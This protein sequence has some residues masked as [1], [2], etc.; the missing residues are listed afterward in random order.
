MT[1]TIDILMVTYN[2]PESTR[3]SL[4]RLLD[5]CTDGMHVWLWHNGDHEETLAVVHEL[6]DHP[7][8][9]K[10]HHSA[11]NQRLWAPSNWLFENSEADLLSKVDDDNVVSPDWAERLSAAHRDYDRF[12]VL[13][14]WRFQDEDLV[15]ELAERKIA[16]YGGHRIM[17]NLWVEGSCFL[18]KRACRDESGLL[19]PGQSMT[20]YFRALGVD[21]G[22]IN[23]WLYPFVRYE[24]LDDPRAEHALVKTDEEFRRRMPLT[25]QYN[26]VQSVAEWTDQLRRSARAVQAASP[27]PR[28]WKGWRQQRRRLKRVMRRL[29]GQR[30]HW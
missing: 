10:F 6:A 8:V 3:L 21:R 16:E 1:T 7:A 4:Q 23:G 19:K 28:D 17:R 27:E 2:S 22:W 25:A 26:G 12:G 30:S 9:A 24:N 5:S 18:M 13:G 20:R 29:L 11:E 15:P 14:S